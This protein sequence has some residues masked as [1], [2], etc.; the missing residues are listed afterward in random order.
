[1]QMMLMTLQIALAF[2]NL[3]I[4]LFALYKF[5][6]KPHDTLLDRITK[7]EVKVDE[8]SDSLKQ[9]ND[10]FKD[11]EEKFE[12]QDQTNKVIIRS[13]LALIEFE[14]QYCLTE[15]KEPSKGLEKAKDDLNEYLSSK[16]T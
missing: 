10:R 14:I 12:K 1:M 7:L 3:G 9:G 13:T 6:K 15:H 5:L 4:M 11:H 8:I 2:C 16:R